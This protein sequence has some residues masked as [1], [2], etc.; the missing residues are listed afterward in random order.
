MG[1]EQ[2]GSGRAAAIAAGGGPFIVTDTVDLVERIFSRMGY[3]DS[4]LNTNMEDALWV[5][6]NTTMNKRNLRMF[7]NVVSDGICPR[8]SLEQ[9]KYAFLSNEV[10]G[11]WQLPPSDAR[12]R[13]L[14]VS[15][16]FLS[17]ARAPKHEVFR[18]LKRMARR[19]G[20]PARKTYNAYVAQLQAHVTE[21]DVF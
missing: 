5:F 9:L 14:L 6:T 8:D 13:S 15:R 21:N 20:L 18:A 12:A 1:I 7:N 10:A 4:D 17:N 3:M 2:H 11:S 19:I 16:G